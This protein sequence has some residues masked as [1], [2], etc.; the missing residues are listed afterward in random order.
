M[1]IMTG[2]T[3]GLTLGITP[4]LSFVGKLLIAFTMFAGRLG[5]LT[6]AIAV[7]SNQVKSSYRYPE[8]RIMIG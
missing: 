5:P 7:W 6:I 2:C 8:E 4:I 3:V 1:G